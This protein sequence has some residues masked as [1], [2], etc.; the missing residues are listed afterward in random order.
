M[1]L[2]SLDGQAFV[3]AGDERFDDGAATP[4]RSTPAELAAAG[5]R[6]GE[7]TSQGLIATVADS[8]LICASPRG[9]DPAGLAGADSPTARRAYLDPRT[10]AL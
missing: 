2:A 10:G 4:R 6:L 9:A 1:R 8:L 3:L 5:A 7:V